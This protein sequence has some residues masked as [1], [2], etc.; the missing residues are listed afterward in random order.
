MKKILITVLVIILGVSLYA[1][2]GVDTVPKDVIRLGIVADL[3]GPRNSF[4]T[5]VSQGIELAVNEINASGGVYGKKFEIVSKDTEG[6]DAGVQKSIKKLIDSR[7]VSF[8]FADGT[9]A[10]NNIK[11][12]ILEKKAITMIVSGGLIGL[13]KDNPYM[14][15]TWPSDSIPVHTLLDYANEVKYK[16]VSIVTGTSE[17]DMIT[18]KAFERYA[19]TSTVKIGTAVST[20]DAALVQKIA[21][22]AP[23]A[24]FVSIESVSELADF[25]TT[26]RQAGIK[27]PILYPYDVTYTNF[28]AK[29]DPESLKSFVYTIYQPPNPMFTNAYTKAYGISPGLYAD[30]AYDAVYMLK[31]AIENASSTDPSIVKDHFEVYQ[32]MSGDIKF[33]ADGERMQKNIGLMTFDGKTTTAKPL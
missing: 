26:I 12:F 16:K 3:S 7:H 25:V 22:E 33:N 10:I 17:E 23:G 28:T 30:T 1:Y 9:S 14:F 27:A 19:S 13:T 20:Q 24:I 18:E 11:P 32:G 29:V 6:T 4:G 15:R 8:V 21:D 5:N 2:F 31:K